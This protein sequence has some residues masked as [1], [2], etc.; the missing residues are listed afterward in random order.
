MAFIPVRRCIVFQTVRNIKVIAD[1]VF[2]SGSPQAIV[3]RI[4]E[5]AR[6]DSPETRPWEE[7]LSQL[8]SNYEERY[9]V[10]R[11]R[12]TVDLHY[13]DGRPAWRVAVPNPPQFRNVRS[14]IDFSL[15]NLKAAS[16]PAYWL[17]LYD[18]P[19]QPYFVHRVLDLGDATVH[20]PED[21]KGTPRI[22]ADER[23]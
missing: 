15:F 1:L 22:N 17:R 21:S 5:A 7:T 19:H 23:E 11:N 20:R 3:R 13:V 10:S 12:R 4:A 18:I 9:A 16:L 14:E 8:S 2:F 6:R